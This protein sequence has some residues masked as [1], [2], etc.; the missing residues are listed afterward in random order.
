MGLV[1]AI[2]VRPTRLPDRRAYARPTERPTPAYDHEYLFLLSEMDPVIHDAVEFGFSDYV[3]NT[4]YFPVFWFINGRNG[5]DTLADTG[6]PWLP[7]Q[8]Y[9]A[10]A[11]MHPGEKVLMRVVGA[12]RDLHPFHH[13]GNHAR[14]IARDGRLL[15]CDGAG[16]S[17]RAEDFTISR[18]PGDDRRRDLRL[19]R[20]GSGLGH[21]RRPESGQQEQHSPIPVQ[22]AGHDT[23]SPAIDPDHR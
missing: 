12:G 23:V 3:D 7:N 9:N 13:H 16:R 19:D 20:Q 22:W 18:R 1:G 14:I 10:L 15:A 21:L 17:G 11:R 6:V 5:P 4:E 2:I 8:P